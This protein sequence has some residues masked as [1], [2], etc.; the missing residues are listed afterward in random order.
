[1]CVLSRAFT[2]FENNFPMYDAALSPASCQI[3]LL[4]RTSCWR[5]PNHLPSIV[6]LFFV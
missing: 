6:F 2:I 3:F 5:V 1:V 4:D